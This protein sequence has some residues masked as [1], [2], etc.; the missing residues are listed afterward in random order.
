[1]RYSGEL[2]AGVEQVL[3]VEHALDL[4]VQVARPRWPLARQ[5]AVLD[6]PEPSFADIAFAVLA[7]T[8][9]LAG[10]PVIGALAQS[11]GLLSA[12]WLIAALFL[13]AFATAGSL[14]PQS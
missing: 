8:A 10:P 9:G 11:V 5:C 7:G 13:A 3:R 6:E 4:L 1:M 14:R 2:L 12:L